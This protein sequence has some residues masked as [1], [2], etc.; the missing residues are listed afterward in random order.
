MLNLPFTYLTI[1]VFCIYVIGL[2]L[3][4]PFE[5]ISYTDEFLLMLSIFSIL[6]RQSRSV[7]RFRKVFILSR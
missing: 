2:E 1:V 7:S 4:I 6:M 5:A 3:F